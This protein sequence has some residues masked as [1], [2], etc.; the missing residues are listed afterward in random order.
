MIITSARSSMLNNFDLCQTQCFISYCL[1]KKLKAGL[2]AEIGSAF[3]LVME[4][5]ALFKKA[6]QENTTS[7]ENDKLGHFDVTDDY[8][9]KDYVNTIVRKSYEYYK[10]HS[11]N[12]F[13][14]K[15]F[16]QIQTWTHAL[17]EY[18][19]GTFDPRKR[20]IVE[21][22]HFFDLPIT[23]KWAFYNYPKFGLMGNLHILGTIDLITKITDEIYEIV[24]FKTGRLFD[25]AKNREKTPEDLQYDIQPRLYHYVLYNLYPQVKQFIL[26]FYYCQANGPITI[27]FDQSDRKLTEELIK[28]K[29]EKI[30][31]T[32]Y[33]SRKS[34]DW[35][36]WF[37]NR[38]CNAYK[39]PSPNPNQ[40]YCQ[41]ISEKLASKGAT[42]TTL[43]EK[44]K[45]FTFGSYVQN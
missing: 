21:A 16:Q 25:F 17:L 8:L 19:N 41:Y 7:F 29:F 3:H 23:K 26:T 44:N 31:Q 18:N 38:V 22:E 1:G 36:N 39:L 12:E 6:T 35:K 4:I 24:D 20:N 5:L 15:N 32:E 42:Q 11:E 30:K 27:A 13:T 33:P 34:R 28:E 45:N 10:S 9:N 37:C 2:K 40:H 43:E 14:E